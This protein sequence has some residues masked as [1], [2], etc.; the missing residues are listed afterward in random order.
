MKKTLSQRA[1]WTGVY[2]AAA[3]LL[4][5]VE[6]LIPLPIP[7]LGAKVGLPNLAVLLALYRWG[8]REAL[9]VQAVR[10][11]I[12]GLLF[13]NL[14][15]IAF[16]LAG[17]LLSLP[18]MWLAAKRGGLTEIG[19]SIA[20][21]AAHNTGQLAAAVCLVGSWRLLAYYPLLLVCAVI[22]GLAIG[23]GVRE[24]RKRMGKDT[25]EP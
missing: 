2:A 4:G 6:L 16:S 17:G 11:L 20:G 5:Y 22:A 21:A 18:V 9:T 7:V 1:A 24:I 23:I 3:V 25:I 13:G 15:S 14:F 19:V 10:I 12:T 8:L